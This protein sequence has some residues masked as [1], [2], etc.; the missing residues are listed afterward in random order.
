ME[1][2]EESMCWGRFGRTNERSRSDG[3]RV[4]VSCGVAAGAN[5]L[6]NITSKPSQQA[7]ESLGLESP[8]C[9]INSGQ[10]CWQ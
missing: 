8:I 9:P 2:S 5:A 6:S 7:K 10:K 3:L 4:G 1:S